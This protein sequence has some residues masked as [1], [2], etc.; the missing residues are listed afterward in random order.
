M[1]P[2]AK[3]KEMLRIKKLEKK[4]RRK[5]RALAEAAAWLVPQKKAQGFGGKRTTT[6]S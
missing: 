5:D 3:R 1:M 6:D 4:V 2:T